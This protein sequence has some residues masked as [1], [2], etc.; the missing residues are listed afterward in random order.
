MTLEELTKTQLILLVLLL[1]FVSSIATSIITT[2]LLAEA[3]LQTTQTINRIV[4]STIEKVTPGDTSGGGNTVVQVVSNESDLIAKIYADT[5]AK[6]YLVTD[7]NGI[8]V[9]TFSINSNKIIL[10]GEYNYLRLP[11]VIEGENKYSLTQDSLVNGL[12]IRNL[13]DTTL[14]LKNSIST[15]QLPKVGETVIIID[16]VTKT[17]S[18]SRIA[19]LEQT[20]SA[21]S[22]IILT[23]SITENT[24]SIVMNLDGK[25]LGFIGKD[26]TGN[27]IVVPVGSVL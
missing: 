21:I 27:K 13:E 23:D 26:D 25:A 2:G 16:P 18:D 24:S 11:S 19:N 22:E 6:V 12:R 7:E 3:P 20:D 4:Q 10:G 5:I 15:E 17:L 8:D 1:C 9:K 14:V